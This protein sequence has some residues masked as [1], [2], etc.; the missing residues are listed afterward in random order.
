[1]EYMHQQSLNATIAVKVDDSDTI[2]PQSEQKGFDSISEYQLIQPSQA[3]Q[4]APSQPSS[5]KKRY[6]CPS[7]SSSSSR[8]YAAQAIQTQP[9]WR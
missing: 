4:E 6:Y 1:M 2:P 5:I 7:F 8:D 9:G 3:D